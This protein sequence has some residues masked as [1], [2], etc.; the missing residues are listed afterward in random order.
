MT[1]KIAAADP[2]LIATSMVPTLT[3]SNPGECGD[4]R[5][6]AAPV[7]LARALYI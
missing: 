2:A 7:I 6:R 5:T 4:H 3:F 1:M